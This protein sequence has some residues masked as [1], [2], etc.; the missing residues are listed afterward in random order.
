MRK[1]LGA[2]VAALM[3]V[4]AASGA[5]S[6]APHPDATFRTERAYFH[7][8]GDV[9]V[10]NVTAQQGQRTLWNT[11]PPSASVTEG[12]GCGQFDVVTVGTVNADPIFEGT[13]T[14]NVNSLTVHLHEMSH[15]DLQPYGTEVLV[16]L[17]V[18]GQT[19]LDHAGAQRLTM[20]PENEG[21]TNGTA[22]TITGLGLDSEAGNGTA[23]HTF[24]MK[25]SSPLRGA[26]L[27]VWDTTEVP[28]G[29]TFNPTTPAATVFPAT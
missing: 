1:V 26:S 25:I 21:V 8:N 14:G 22:F 12:A 18:D 11:T 16:T 4:V 13:F 10:Q 23:T 19:R 9:K 28:A 20:V 24:A 29:I 27:W 3:M 7:C 2:V 15:S 5:A 17:V 6:A